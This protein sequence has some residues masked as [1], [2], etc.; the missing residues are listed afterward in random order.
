MSEPRG[1][2]MDIKMKILELLKK[3]PMTVGELA[4]KLGMNQREVMK[5]LSELT[6]RGKIHKGLTE[7]RRYNLYGV[8]A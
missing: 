8:K 4:F 7:N 2:N 5:H 1:E 6:V 3:E